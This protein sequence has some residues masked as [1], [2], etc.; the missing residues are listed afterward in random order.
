MGVNILCA[1]LWVRVPRQ[2][3]GV[4]VNTALLGH[5]V[6]MSACGLSGLSWLVVF[7]LSYKPACLV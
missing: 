5:P 2:L 1:V 7:G 4:A 3:D 6:E